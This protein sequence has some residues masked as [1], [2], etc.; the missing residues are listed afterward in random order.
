MNTLNTPQG[1]ATFLVLCLII[2]AV[3]F[4]VFSAAGGALGASMFSRRRD[5]R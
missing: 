3:A 2:M 1:L 5:L 4:V